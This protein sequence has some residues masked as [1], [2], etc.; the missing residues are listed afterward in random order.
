MGH[1]RRFR[2]FRGEV[3]STSSSGKIVASQRIDVD[4]QQLSFDASIRAGDIKRD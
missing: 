3:R 4:G 2:D 1:E